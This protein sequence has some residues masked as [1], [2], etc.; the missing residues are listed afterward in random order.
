VGQMRDWNPKSRFYTCRA[1]QASSGPLGPW[2]Y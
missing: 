2:P 1:Y